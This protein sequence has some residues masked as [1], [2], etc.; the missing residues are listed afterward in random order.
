MIDKSDRLALHS[1]LVRPV[2][3]SEDVYAHIDDFLEILAPYG[4]RISLWEHPL[5]LEVG[6]DLF[7]NNRNIRLIP[8]K[9][10]YR[11]VGFETDM[12]QKSLWEILCVI[13]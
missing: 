11:V 10:G 13:R 2:R 8:T 5:L 7:V 9:K 12:P 6:I 4:C 1:L 3:K